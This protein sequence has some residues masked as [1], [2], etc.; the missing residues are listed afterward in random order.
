MNYS[1]LFKK[2]DLNVLITG[3]SLS[4]NRYGYDPEGRGNAFE[5]GAGMKS[6]S[7]RLRDKI[8]KLDKQF[9]FAD[10]LTFNCETVSGLGNQ[11]EI[12]NTEV[13]DGKSRTLLPQNDVEFTVNIKSN[14]IVLYLQKRIDCPVTFD[15]YIDGALAL[16]KVDTTGAMD[17]FAGYGFYILKLDCDNT[18]ETHLVE[19]K[20]IK[21][22]NKKITLAAVGSVYRKV[23]LNGKGS[24]C[25]S[26][27][28]ENFEER[29]AKHNPDL[30]ILILSENN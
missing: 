3:D 29:I 25:V 26:F 15:I 11:S 8:Y 20:N 30:A 19:F 16:E 2:E 13:F 22:E 21:G 12:P 4:Y 14:Q 7:F 18:K 17:D 1:E 6:W 5:C 28:L 27:F 10:A 9:T 24:Q 23:V